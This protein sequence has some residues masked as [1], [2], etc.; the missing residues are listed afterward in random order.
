MQKAQVIAQQNLGVAAK[1]QKEYYDAGQTFHTYNAGDLVWCLSQLNQ[2]EMAPK[3]RNSYDGPFLVLWKNNDLNY[4]VQFGPTG[5]RRVLHY[6]KL[7]PCVVERR[8]TWVGKA[9]KRFL[10]K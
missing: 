7:K 3:L 4:L 9:M 2:L 8:P 10:R 5:P 1:R 6:N